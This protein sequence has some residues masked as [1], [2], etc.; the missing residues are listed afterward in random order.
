MSDSTATKFM[1]RDLP[2]F[3]KSAAE[4]EADSLNNYFIKTATYLSAVFEGS[5]KV[6][7]IGHRGSGKTALFRRLTHEYSQG[8]SVVLSITPS[9]FSYELFSK[10][11][12]DIYDIKIIYGIV[13]QYT[14]LIYSF[15]S[16]IEDFQKRKIK[17]HRD[18][19]TIINQ[20]LKSGDA[21]DASSI[22]SIFLGFLRKFRITKIGL[23]II[24]IEFENMNTD[25]KQL[26]KL[27]NMDD[28]RSAKKAFDRIV[29]STPLYIFI[30]ELDTGWN[31]SEEAKNFLYGLL[32]AVGKLKESRGVNV[33]LSLRKDMYDN[34]P[35]FYTDAEKLRD[36]IEI[37][38]WNEDNLK[39]LIA[40]RIMNFLP[41][42]VSKN[43]SSPKDA[44]DLVFEEEV[45]EYMIA[46]TLRRPREVIQFC[47]LA[48]DFFKRAWHFNVSHSGR[49]TLEM[50]E[51]V[52][53]EF[54]NARIREICQ[55]YSYQYPDLKDFLFTFEHS[56]Q[57]F[58]YEEFRNKLEECLLHFFESHET[59]MWL[60]TY[61]ERI[62]DL[63]RVL[64]DVGFIE[65]YAPAFERYFAYYELTFHHAGKINGVKIHDLFCAA[66]KLKKN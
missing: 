18:Y 24:E 37:L 66:L 6:F 39:M 62:N 1:L 56:R 60:E 21:L 58:T 2:S 3:G 15:K 19:V 42:D 4:S 59:G 31:N 22:E 25:Q 8:N 23:K 51:I 26:M 64:F 54:S 14:L 36:D 13:W 30:D 28:I 47:N 44:I 55:E 7:Y 11:E 63:I 9:D 33:F 45:L 41:K 65:L 20:Y 35:M 53:N 50:A 27:L 32:Y 17:R 61:F 16:I 34:L 40:S 10:V 43:V 38:N 48:L 12:H 29:D 49:V 46:H 5:R 57:Y 52:E